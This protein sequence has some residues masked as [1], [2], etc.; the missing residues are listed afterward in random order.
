MGF[1]VCAIII[2]H[3]HTL[4]NLTYWNHHRSVPI[5]FAIAGAVVSFLFLDPAA[6]SFVAALS[7]TSP[8]HLCFP[9][10]VCLSFSSRILSN[11][12]CLRPSLSKQLAEER[13]AYNLSRIVTQEAM[14]LLEPVGL[15]FCKTNLVTWLCRVWDV[16]WKAKHDG[17]LSH[18]ISDYCWITIGRM[19]VRP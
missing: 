1:C 19:A 7:S 16:R 10:I 2:S 12:H 18:C 3:T 5:S 17:F 14:A 4:Q 11:S 9:S 8:S 13:H 15:Q 6:F